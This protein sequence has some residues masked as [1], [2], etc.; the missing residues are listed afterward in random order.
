MHLEADI[1][2]LVNDTGW[3]T[4][5]IDFRKALEVYCDVYQIILCEREL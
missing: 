5:K 4:H 1:S 2:N 3:M